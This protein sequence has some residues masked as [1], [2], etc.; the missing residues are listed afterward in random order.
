MGARVCVC[1]VFVFAQDSE[2][3]R[4]SCGSLLFWCLRREHFDSTRKHQFM[5]GNDV[6]QKR[7][8]DSPPPRH[9]HLLHRTSV[10]LLIMFVAA[11]GLAVV[12][13]PS[14]FASASD[15]ELEAPVSSVARRLALGHWRDRRRQ[16]RHDARQ[17]G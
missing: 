3:A 14:T 5:L 8:S 10:G 17:R 11:Y 4:A 12:T 9:H 1:L 16:R 13:S 2:R 15:Q 7:A 6:E